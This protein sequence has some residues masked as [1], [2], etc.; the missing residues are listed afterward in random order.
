MTTKRLDQKPMQVKAQTHKQIKELSG[1]LGITMTEFLAELMNELYPISMIYNG[2][3]VVHYLPSYQSSQIIVQYLGKDRI[4]QSGV[5]A[6]KVSSGIEDDALE[7]QIIEQ[8]KVN[9]G[10]S[11]ADVEKKFSKVVIK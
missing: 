4:L 7:Q 9:K 3:I 10:N 5:F 11:F 6:V 8:I 2:H 1:K